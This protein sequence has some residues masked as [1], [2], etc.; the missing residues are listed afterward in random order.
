MEPL[1]PER[2]EIVA[3]VPP[4]TTQDQVSIMM[5]NLLKERFHLAYHLEK[6]TLDVVEL[7]VAKGGSKLK[8]A[9]I[10]AELPALGP[11]QGNKGEDGYPNVP[12]GRPLGIGMVEGTSMDLFFDIPSGF[13]LASQ[14]PIM[15]G[16]AGKLMIWRIGMRMYT[17]PLLMNWLQHEHEIA[18]I[19]DH[20]GL[21]GKYDIKLRFSNGVS[22]GDGDASEPA[23]DIAEALEKQLGLKLQR[24]KAPLDVIVIDHID[25]LPTEN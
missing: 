10:P 25:K 1:G 24:T 5:Q 3:N 21:T 11:L 14:N 17:I 23:P 7:T 18:H 4:G 8:D 6:R 19:V 12:P 22:A 9:E 2:F 13:L 15:A 16:G 20:T